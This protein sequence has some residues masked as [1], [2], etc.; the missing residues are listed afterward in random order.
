MLKE[1]TP[2]TMATMTGN[3]M[4]KTATKKVFF[5]SLRNQVWLQACDTV[6][7]GKERRRI[8]DSTQVPVTLQGFHGLQFSP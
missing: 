2:A 8:S 3:T 5:P 7:I 6:N 1:R 4:G